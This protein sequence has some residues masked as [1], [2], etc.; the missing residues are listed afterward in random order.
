MNWGLI[1]SEFGR[2]ADVS[3]SEDVLVLVVLPGV[4]DLADVEVVLVV[5]ILGQVHDE[6]GLEIDLIVAIL[7]RGQLVQPFFPIGPHGLL[8]SGQGDFAPDIIQSPERLHV[9]HGEGVVLVLDTN[10]HHPVVAALGV[11]RALVQL[12]RVQGVGAPQAD[13]FVEEGEVVEIARAED[14]RVHFRR[15]AILEM[16]NLAL[17][18]SHAWPLRDFLGPFKSHRAGPGKSSQSKVNPDQKMILCF[19]RYY[20]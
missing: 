20:L 16:D 13:G 6:V 9:K 2:E 19:Q 8:T 10:I 1:S 15:G 11:D 7:E 17:D 3:V 18:M 5:G 12:V 14:D 4:E